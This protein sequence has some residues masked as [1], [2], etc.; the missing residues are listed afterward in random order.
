[1]H[2]YAVFQGQY[3]AS[4]AKLAQETFQT[5]VRFI[6]TA[7]NPVDPIGSLPADNEV[8]PVSTIISRDETDWTIE[9]NWRM[10]LGVNDFDPGDWLN[11]QLAPAMV[12]FFGTGLF[13]S[14]AYIRQIRVYPIDST[15]HV[16]PAA[17]FAT[18]TPVVLTYK[19]E[20]TADGGGSA[21]LLPAQI[22]VVASTRTAQVGRSSRGRMFLPALDSQE[23]QA[24]GTFGT[25][26]AN[27]MAGNVSTFLEACQVVPGG[28]GVSCLPAVIP[29]NWETYALIN[30]VRVGDV[31]D[32]QRRRRR[33][34]PEVYS[35]AVVDNPV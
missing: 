33:A 2:L 6:C 12:T 32:T 17:P 19:A 13:A 18:G 10:E 5:G 7:A 1:M 20:T 3:K 11:D 22:S 31:Y 24:N 21:A 15:G 25:S 26:N 14:L 34:L 16:A 28:P 27:T 29:T 9:G 30:S 35:S 4:Q 8:Y 23:L